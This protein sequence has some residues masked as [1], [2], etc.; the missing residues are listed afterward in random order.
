MKL[1]QLI[2]NN[3]IS[4]NRGVQDGAYSNICYSLENNVW[5]SLA[6]MNSVR[7]YAAAAQLPEGKLLVTGG[8]DAPKV[9]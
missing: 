9:V 5:V 6:I 3:Y 2:M 7:L 8:F 4:T 1:T